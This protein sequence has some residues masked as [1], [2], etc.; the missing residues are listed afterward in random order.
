ML[1]L[2]GCTQKNTLTMHSLMNVTFTAVPLRFVVTESRAIS[3][4]PA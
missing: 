3:V 4:V 2:V 1:H